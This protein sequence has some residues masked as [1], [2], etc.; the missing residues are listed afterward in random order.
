M[1]KTKMLARAQ[2]RFLDGE[3][4]LEDYTARL[5]QICVPREGDSNI[6]VK[7]PD[8]QEEQA[9]YKERRTRISGC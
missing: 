3:L 8:L 5:N 4:S 7:P 1:V 2:R 6:T 9:M